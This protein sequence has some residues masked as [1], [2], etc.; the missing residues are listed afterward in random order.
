M[1]ESKV[2]L[3][4]PEGIKVYVVKDGVKQDITENKLAGHKHDGKFKQSY[5]GPG[6]KSKLEVKD[7]ALPAVAPAFAP[8]F[9]S[10]FASPAFATPFAPAFAS[11]FSY[12]V[13][14]GFGWF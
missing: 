9:A 4:I 12:G 13:A 2:K 11:P 6:I 14:P 5:C 3:I 10:A 8:A 1:D 7:C